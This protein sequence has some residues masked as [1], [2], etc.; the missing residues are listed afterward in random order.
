MKWKFRQFL[1]AD[2][3]PKLKICTL[4]AARWRTTIR[5]SA[6]QLFVAGFD[7]EHFDPPAIAST[8]DRSKN[9]DCP[10]PRI[11]RAAIMV[12]CSDMAVQSS[13]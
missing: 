12:K 2:Q 8:R 3:G 5:R 4:G 1:A 9:D 13:A 6:G 10:D 11:E 7:D